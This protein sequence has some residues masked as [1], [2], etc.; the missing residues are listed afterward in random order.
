MTFPASPINGAIT[1]VNGILYIYDSAKNTW[2]RVPTTINNEFQ[3]YANS[4]IGNIQANLGTLYLGNVST[5]AN[6]GTIQTTLL[7]IP[8]PVVMAIVFGG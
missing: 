4:T 5:N 6:I 8:D 7:A 2:K 3:T 1:T